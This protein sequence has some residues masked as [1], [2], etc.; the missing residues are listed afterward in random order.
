MGSEGARERGREGVGEGEGEGQVHPAF[1]SVCLRAP[2]PVPVR[3][4]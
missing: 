4:L 3:Q 1:P 2:P